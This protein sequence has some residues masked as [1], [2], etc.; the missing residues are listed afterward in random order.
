MLSSWRWDRGTARR[1]SAHC[2]ALMIPKLRLCIIF[3]PSAFRA[4]D[5]PIVPGFHRARSPLNFPQQPP[6][7]RI[8]TD[9]HRSGGSFGR[10][11]L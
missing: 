5:Q 9:N 3:Q 7:L 10:H 2:A 8:S 6:T 4:P 1:S 11:P